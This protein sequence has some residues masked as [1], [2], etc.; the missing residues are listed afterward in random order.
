MLDYLTQSLGIYV[1][2]YYNV[3]VWVVKVI[4]DAIVMTRMTRIKTINQSVVK[5]AY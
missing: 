2:L 4:Y 5:H 1:K 3:V